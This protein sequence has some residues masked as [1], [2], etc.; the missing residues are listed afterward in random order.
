MASL[1]AGSE[2]SKA[3][4]PF[5]PFWTQ[6]FGPVTGYPTTGSPHAFASSMT[7]PKVSFCDGKT[8]TSAFRRA[9]PTPS[10]GSGP[11]KWTLGYFL[12]RVLR[13]EPPPTR[14]QWNP[15]WESEQ[16][17]SSPFSGWALETHIRRLDCILSA[18]CFHAGGKKWDSSTPLPQTAMRSAGARR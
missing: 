2:V 13:Y 14:V 15:L 17:S 7:S 11:L 4:Y 1:R 9:L 16:K 6:S 5:F 12:L 10:G 3:R 18:L 8:N